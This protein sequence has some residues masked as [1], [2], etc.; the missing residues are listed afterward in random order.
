MSTESTPRAAV[1]MRVAAVALEDAARQLREE[2]AWIERNWPVS[3]WTTR[4]A[5]DYLAASLASRESEVTRATSNALAA[6]TTVVD[7]ST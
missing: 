7:V 3:T 4:T 6:L 1:A 5:D 2:A